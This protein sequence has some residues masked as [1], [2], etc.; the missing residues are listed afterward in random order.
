MNAFQRKMAEHLSLI[1]TLVM[2][3]NCRSDEFS[4][5]FDTNGAI[6]SI[7]IYA[8]ESLEMRG[9]SQR[10]EGS[11]YQFWGLRGYFDR[12]YGDE[13][14]LRCLTTDQIITVLHQI[15]QAL[16][17]G[18]NHDEHYPATDS[19]HT[20]TTGMDERNGTH[21]ALLTE[22]AQLCHGSVERTGGQPTG[23]VSPAL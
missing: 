10:K 8:Y 23:S 11:S 22:P 20:A 5:N 19:E 6:S 14:F 13:P 21:G 15:R 3:I 9:K 4:L 18:R 2:D 12:D 1:A 7:T 16:I 17:E